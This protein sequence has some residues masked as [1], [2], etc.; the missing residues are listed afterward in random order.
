[1]NNRPPLQEAFGTSGWSNWFTQLFQCLPWK[2]ALNVTA[3][4]DFPMVIVNSQAAL[5]VAVTG[6]R[7][8]DAVEVTPYEDVSGIIFTGV[9]TARDTV[10]VYAKNIG[11]GGIN[12]PSTQFR[13]IVK[14]D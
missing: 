13:I 12:P 10:T 7:Q 6:A 14:Q 3:T 8:G 9:V 4:L 5:T 1:M 11:G 2:K